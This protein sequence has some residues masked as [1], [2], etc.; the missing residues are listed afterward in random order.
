LI[1]LMRILFELF[2]VF[3]G[4]WLSPQSKLK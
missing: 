4:R 2:Y 1:D 3:V